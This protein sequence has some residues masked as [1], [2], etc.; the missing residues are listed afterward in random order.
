MLDEYLDYITESINEARVKI[1]KARI[2]GGKVQRKV[3]VATVAGYTMRGGKVTKMK[4]SE[5]L[6]RKIAQKKGARKRK[7][8]Q[9]RAKIHAMRSRRK[10]KSLGL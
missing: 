2:R 7:A 8:V 5:R 1:V 3:K 9:A 6:H 10:R 4:A